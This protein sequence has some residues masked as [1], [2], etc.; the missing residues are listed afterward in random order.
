MT[1]LSPSSSASSSANVPFARQWITLPTSILGG[2]RCGSAFVRLGGEMFLI[3]GVQ[4]RVSHIQP[5]QQG[6]RNHC[7]TVTK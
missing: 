5:Q 1:S 3:G 4:Q 7:G 6:D 2:P